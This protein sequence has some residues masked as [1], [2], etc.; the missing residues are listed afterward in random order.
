M[1][2]VAGGGGGRRIPLQLNKPEKTKQQTKDLPV[3]LKADDVGL[4]R[5]LFGRS[6]N[7]YKEEHGCEGCSGS[8][9]RRDESR[10]VPVV[11]GPL[12]PT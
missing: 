5:L 7:P 2:T 10:N 8:G 6:N 1:V 4:F 12:L 3:W 9:D 11:A